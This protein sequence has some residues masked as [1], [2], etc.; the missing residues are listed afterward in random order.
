MKPRTK[1]KESA[2]PGPDRERTAPAGETGEERASLRD[3]ILDAGL[4]LMREQGTTRLTQADV[5]RAAGVP[6]G[7]LTYYFP[8]KSDLVTALARRS[9]EAT[10]QDLARTLSGAQWTTEPSEQRARVLEIVKTTSRDTQRTQLLLGV[11]LASA[12]DRE[13]QQQLVE[14]IALV[15]RLIAAALGLSGEEG[16]ADV[17]IILAA[18]WGLGITHLIHRDLRAAERTDALHDR[19][20]E[21]VEALRAPQ[22]EAESPPPRARAR[23]R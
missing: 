23:K 2:A 10:V 17:E 12:E 8:R 1:G 4:S 6:Q 15:R 21:W 22:P 16:D 3:R 11:A 13:L 7:H 14:S 5:A 18:L 9:M 20:A 19:L